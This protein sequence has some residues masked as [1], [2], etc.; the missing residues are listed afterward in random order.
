LYKI[1][2]IIQKLNTKKFI[3]SNTFIK[4][5]RSAKLT[6]Y[7]PWDQNKPIEKKLKITKKAFKKKVML[8]VKIVKTINKKVS[9]TSWRT[10]Q[11]RYPYQ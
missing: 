4:K 2:W 3:F 9:H 6:V 8:N 10:C 5:K 7:R 1:K 11:I